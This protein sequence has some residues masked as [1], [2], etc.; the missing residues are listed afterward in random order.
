[1][2]FKLFGILGL[3]L[4]FALGLGFWMVKVTEQLKRKPANAERLN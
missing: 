4:V 3:T 1:M 2:N